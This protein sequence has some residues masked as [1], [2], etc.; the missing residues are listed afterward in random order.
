MECQNYG[1]YLSGLSEKACN[2]HGGTWCPSADQ[3]C[4]TLKTCIEQEIAWAETDSHPAYGRYLSTAP[5]ITDPTDFELCGETREYF[6]FSALY[7]N[8]FEVCEAIEQLRYSRDFEMLDGFFGETDDGVDGVEVPDLQVPSLEVE[9]EAGE[10]LIDVELPVYVV[11][12]IQFDT[13]DDCK[14]RM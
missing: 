10:G 7:V 4:S 6:G 14:L 8:D 2:A 9:I 12:P 1:P 13:F 3:D 11:P 5:N